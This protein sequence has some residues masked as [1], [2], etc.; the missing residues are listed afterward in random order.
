MKKTIGKLLA[1][2][3]M[4]AAVLGV[5]CLQYLTDSAAPE[6]DPTA[7]MVPLAQEVYNGYGLEGDQT[8]SPVK[9]A[10][11]DDKVCYEDRVFRRFSYSGQNVRNFVRAMRG[12]KDLHPELDYYVM[13]VPSRVV[14]EEDYP[15]DRESYERF[16][17]ALKDGLD[18]SAVL[19]DP[20]PTLQ[21]HGDEY[22]FFRTEDG[23]TA[24]GAYYGSVE[25][26]RALGIE[27]F[28][29]SDY[30]EYQYE[31]ARGSLAHNTANEYEAVYGENNETAEKLHDMLADPYFFYCLPGAANL[32]EIYD[33]DTGRMSVQPAI[34]LSREGRSGF[35]GGGYLHARLFG[36][37]KSE[38]VGDKTLLMLCDHGGDVLAPF[39]ASYYKNVY[40]VS[41][42]E[43]EGFLDRLNTLLDRYDI[44]SVVVVQQA[45][46]LG[47]KGQS[48]AINDLMG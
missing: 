1:V 31:R 36:D 33:D 14:T 12:L 28:A 24:R 21:E 22:V 13:P 47:N 19:L 30:N 25:L 38:A 46:N 34:S 16:I 20:W 27:P 4:L 15:E 23:W 18:G 17:G 45:H 5:C 2:L 7:S 42:Q 40:V 29:L 6:E 44:D 39:M 3:G 26:C 43:D 32:E 35:V 9:L 8:L 37:G 10:E 48:A 11:I 41:C